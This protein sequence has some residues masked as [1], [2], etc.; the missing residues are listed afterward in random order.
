MSKGLLSDVDRG[1]KIH[2]STLDIR[3]DMKEETG[4]WD[5]TPILYTYG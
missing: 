2:F 5:P 4:G 3:Q 1:L